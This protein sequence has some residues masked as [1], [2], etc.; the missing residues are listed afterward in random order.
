MKKYLLGVLLISSFSLVACT[1]NNNEE[2][3]AQ[4]TEQPTTETTEEEPE[5]TFKDG[6]FDND[7]FT[8]TYEDAKIINSPMENSPGLYVTYTLK[9]KL[10]ENINPQ[11]VLDLIVT[12]TQENDTSEVDLSNDYYS[13]DAFGPE[14]DVDTYNEQV[15]KENAVSND[16]KPGKEVE[17]I[18]AFGLDNKEEPVQLQM[19]VNPE[20]EEYSDPYEIDLKDLEE[21]PGP[22][23]NK[24]EYWDDEAAAEKEPEVVENEKQDIEGA[25]ERDT[26]SEA[27]DDYWEAKEAGLTE[28]EIGEY[29]SN[30]W[31]GNPAEN[32]G[33]YYTDL[34][35]YLS[36]KE[37]EEEQSYE[38][39]EDEEKL[40]GMREEADQWQEAFEAEQGRKAT[41]GE[42]Q[43]HWAELQ[44]W[45]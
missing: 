8:L 35:D 28:D 34:D 36:E 9:N 20:T 22:K 33:T 29:T 30:K 19:L 31:Y 17:I 41:S 45:E 15:D 26:E 11:E 16:L 5:S 27:Q 18:N 2:V 43:S 23:E 4:S 14:D 10:E 40:E 42:I 12:A 25:P 32:D 37:M 13:T 38:P 7:S 44:G 21:I 6:V 24:D 3:S 39:E 1:S